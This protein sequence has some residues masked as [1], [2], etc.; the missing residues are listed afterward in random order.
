MFYIIDTEKQIQELIDENHQSAFIHIIEHKYI[1]PKLNEILLFYYRPLN[2]KKGF[3]CG[4]KTQDALSIPFAKIVELVE[5]TPL[6][7]VICKKNL[8]YHFK[9]SNLLDLSLF[10]N[11]N[12]NT[13]L[14]IEIDIPIFNHVQLNEVIP[15]TKHYEYCEQLFKQIEPLI[16]LVN[17]EDECFNIYN[18]MVIPQLF[19]IERQGLG[20]NLTELNKHLSPKDEHYS[21]DSNIIYGQYNINTLTTRPTNNF[22]NINFSGLNKT[23]GTRKVFIPKND[24]FIE[25]D[26]ESYHPRLL[27]WLVKYKFASDRSLYKQLAQIYFDKEQITAEEILESKIKTFRQIYGGIESQYLNHPYF[28]SVQQFTDKLWFDYNTNGYVEHFVSKLRFYK[29]HL[30]N[31]TPSKLLNYYLQATETMR[32]IYKIQQVNELLENTTTK[33]VLYNYDSFVF[34]VCKSEEKIMEEVNKIL[35]SKEFPVKTKIGDSLSFS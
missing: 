2:E 31:M 32:N 22:N 18:D 33:L 5:K 16:P 15:L 28:S 29:K 11:L 12:N 13:N 21:I 24:Y 25:Y 6:N 26:Y 7:Y 14:K 30:Q 1:H 4:L 9:N 3:I 27:A 8:L 19:D 34:D 10:Y 23:D 35:H 17:P 20:V